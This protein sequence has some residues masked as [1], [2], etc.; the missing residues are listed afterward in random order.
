MKTIIVATDFSE[1]AGEGLREA[2]RLADRLKAQILLAFVQDTTDIR[3]ALKQEIPLSFES[4]REL[5]NELN[6]QIEE[7]FHC[8]IRNFGRRYKEIEPLVLKGIP[9]YQICKLARR[10]NAD[11]IVVGARGLS[12]LKTFFVGSTTQ[13]LIR[14]APCPVLV[15]HKQKRISRKKAVA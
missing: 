3:Y 15:I 11:F 12:P 5:K 13:N 4:S 6:K 14:T 9:W 7:K 8:F 1:N 10:K 2:T